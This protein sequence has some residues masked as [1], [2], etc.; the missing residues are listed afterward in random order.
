MSELAM[1]E[2]ICT[3]PGS[4]TIPLATFTGAGLARGARR[5]AGTMRRRCVRGQVNEEK[6]ARESVRLR[7]GRTP[8]SSEA[9]PEHARAWEHGRRRAETAAACAM[10]SQAPCRGSSGGRNLRA[11]VL[12]FDALP[13]RSAFPGCRHRVSPSS[14][15]V[16][17][18][19][20]G[21]HGWCGAYCAARCLTP[22][23]QRLLFCRW[24]A[25]SPA[26]APSSI[27]CATQTPT[28]RCSR[29]PWGRA[30]HPRHGRHGVDSFGVT[31]A[32]AGQIR[33][34]GLAAT[35]DGLLFVQWASDSVCGSRARAS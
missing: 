4:V 14:S 23:L 20:P 35:P 13:P 21:N 3:L 7:P 12:E 5:R 8:V 34:N 32:G 1:H 29:T 11:N 19:L 25:C 31:S 9:L 16:A 2:G 22:L 18:D 28:T 33:G 10:G 26:A 15:V 24:A 30:Q 6:A 17:A 27:R